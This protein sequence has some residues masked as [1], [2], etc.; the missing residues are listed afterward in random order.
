MLRKMEPVQGEGDVSEVFLVLG[1]L[2]EALEHRPRV[3]RERCA[4]GVGQ[5]EVEAREH[6]LPTGSFANQAQ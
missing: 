3:P 4:L 5:P 1:P 6:V 2:E